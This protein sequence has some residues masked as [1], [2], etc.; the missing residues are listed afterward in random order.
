MG[1]VKDNKEGSIF[2]KHQ[3][4]SKGR[5]YIYFLGYIQVVKQK[6]N[7]KIDCFL[8]ILN[9]RNC[10]EKKVLISVWFDMYSCIVLWI[11]NFMMIYGFQLSVL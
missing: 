9:L 3:K 5:L 11:M 6:T 7:V 8:K 2:K 10:Y 1:E 4:K